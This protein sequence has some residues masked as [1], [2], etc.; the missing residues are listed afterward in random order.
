MEKTVNINKYTDRT[1]AGE[2]LAEQLKNYANQTDVIVLA[3]PRGGVPV[4]YEIAEKLAAPLDV[5]IVR[6]LGMPG[7]QELAIGALAM[8]GTTV[9]NE[10]LLRLAPIPPEVIEEIVKSEQIE[11]NRRLTIYRGNQSLPQLENKIIILVD[12]GIA[13]GATMRAAITVLQ[14]QNLKKLIVATPTAALDTAKVI[15]EMVDQ[16]I[17]PL[18][19][20]LFYSVGSWY[21]DFPQTS[22][23]EV[24]TLLTKAKSF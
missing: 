13:T 17:C 19:P 7:Q 6:K 14:K 21:S 4:A 16:F 9:F 12:D 10:E 18:T 23:A 3:L 5:F 24:I 8:D 22:D 15:T 2:V 20:E 11:L 1:E